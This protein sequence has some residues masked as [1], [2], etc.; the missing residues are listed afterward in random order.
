MNAFINFWLQFFETRR[1]TQFLL[2]RPY[3]LTRFQRAVHLVV[4]TI[5]VSRDPKNPTASSM[6]K[7]QL[8]LPNQWLK[9]NFLPAWSNVNLQLHSQTSNSQHHSRTPTSQSDV[10]WI[11]F[12][13][14]QILCPSFLGMTSST[15]QPIFFLG[16]ILTMVIV[17]S[18]A[19]ERKLHQL[20]THLNS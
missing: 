18:F 8:S 16:F 12:K 15:L 20:T 17:I 14:F 2:W 11:F 1:E 10:N 13:I 4:F 5:S 6:V 3:Y 9:L 7:T 19:R